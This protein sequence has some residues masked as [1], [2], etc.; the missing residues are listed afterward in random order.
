MLQYFCLLIYFGY[1]K[2][3][4]VYFI[5]FDIFMKILTKYFL[6]EYLL[7]K[8]W[9][10]IFNCNSNFPLA[11]LQIKFNQIYFQNNLYLFYKILSGA[12]LYFSKNI[13]CLE[14]SKLN[15]NIPA[16]NI[17]LFYKKILFQIYG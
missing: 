13:L 2:T 8:Y 10:A 16:K 6:L 1:F 12:F 3:F 14:L 17:V 5:I 4:E 15:Y 11:N 7:L 9:F